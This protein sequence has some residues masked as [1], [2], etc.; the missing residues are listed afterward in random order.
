MVA[1]ISQIQSPPNFFLNQIGLLL[2]FPNIL[3]VTCFR[4]KCLLFTYHDFPLQSGDKTA[5]CV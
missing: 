5:M 3:T 4:K 1:R 2:L